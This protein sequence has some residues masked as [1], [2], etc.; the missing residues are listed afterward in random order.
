MNDQWER[1]QPRM[2]GAIPGWC[3]EFYKET[4]EAMGSKPAS[5]HGIF[6]SSCLQ[7]PALF[8]FLSQL[9]Q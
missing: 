7:D 6:I 9:S 1:A 5:I 4:E 3:P 2:G 8:E